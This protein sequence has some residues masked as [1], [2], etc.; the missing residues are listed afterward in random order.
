MGMLL[1]EKVNQQ[2]AGEIREISECGGWIDLGFD[3]AAG[4][5]ESL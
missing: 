5:T 1:V 2:R 3:R 4:A